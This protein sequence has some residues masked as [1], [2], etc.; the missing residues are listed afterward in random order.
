M[1]HPAPAPANALASPL[2][3]NSG[4]RYLSRPLQLSERPYP[5]LVRDAL[6]VASFAVFA[7]IGWAAYAPISE[8]ARAPGEIIPQGRTRTIQ[9]LDGGVIAAIMASERAQVKAGDLVMTLDGTGARQD[10]KEL[11]QAR[12]A[13]LLK[14]ERIKAFLDKRAPDFSNLGA[15]PEAIARETIAFNAMQGDAANEQLLLKEQLAQKVEAAGT[16][17]AQQAMHRRNVSIISRE[18]DSLKKLHDK[19]LITEARWLDA[20]RRLSESQGQ[21]A[22]A[23]SA[24]EQASSTIN[25][26]RQR[27]V[28][29]SNQRGG[30]SVDTLIDVQNQL[31]QLDERYA[32]LAERVNRLEVRAPI[33]G[34]IKGIANRSVGNVV[35]PGE[36]LFEIVPTEDTLIA[37]V[38]IAPQDIGHVKIGQPVRIKVSTYDFA[39]YGALGGTLGMISATTFTDEKGAKYFAATVSLDENH[40]RYGSKDLALLPGMTIEADIVTGE[41]SVLGYLLKPVRVAIEG[42]LSEK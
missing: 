41:K 12:V 30:T 36:T 8:I 31:S 19:G 4:L 40:L 25:E 23:L 34:I 35:K 38:R 27:I 20:Q 32:K 21:L 14:A 7:F 5:G 29:M 3:E 2:P 42:A 39:R 15:S 9:H 24:R 16:Y 18:V 26:Y 37:D 33:T 11:A 1:P 28:T 22:S 10:M 17:D 13:L 6:L